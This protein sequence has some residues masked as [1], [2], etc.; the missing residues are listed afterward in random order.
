MTTL[1]RNATVVCVDAQRQIFS[2]GAVSIDGSRITDIGPSDEV[3]QRNVR[4]ERVIE[5]DGK[6]VLPGFVSAHNHLG[7]AVFRGRAEDFGYGAGRHL[8]LPMA[9]VLRREERRDIGWLAAAELLRGGVTTVFEMEEDGDVLT[10]PMEHLGLRGCVGVMVSDVDVDKRVAGETVFSEQKCAQQLAQAIGFAENQKAKS[11]SRI[12]PVLAANSLATSSPAQL[13]ALRDAAERL[14]VRLSIHLGTGEAPILEHLYG[15]GAVDF[16]RD[17]GFLAPDV[18]AVHGYK[19][20]HDEVV[21]FSRTGA[22]LAHCP[23]INSFRGLVTPLRHYRENGV[24]VGLGIDNFFSDTFDVMRSCISSARIRENDPRALPAAEVLALATV[25]AART[26]GLDAQIGSLEVGKHA[27][28]QI[29][30]MRKYSLTPVTDPITTLVYHAHA[31][32]VETVM[33]D[34][35]VRVDN[36]IVLSADEDSLV[37]NAAGAA[38]AAWQRFTERFGEPTT[39]G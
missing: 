33:I 37:A 21:A 16:A 11:A 31:K 14:D 2:P 34:G 26:L 8:Y 38:Q 25:G 3:E 24:N 39:S 20:T 7:Y 30:D 27:D 13:R 29:V 23:Q 10:G 18:I 22:H 15:I 4:A 5:G 36:S 6:I 19:L 32:D 1:I 28:L 12:G 35:E 17:N 9:S